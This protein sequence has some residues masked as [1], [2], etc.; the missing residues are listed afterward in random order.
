MSPLNARR[1]QFRWTGDAAPLEENWFHGRGQHS[2]SRDLVNGAR[3]YQLEDS[4]R[5][6][7]ETA[8]ELG[9]PLLVTG[10]PGTGKTQLAYYLAYKLGCGE[11][12]RFQVKSN[13][14][15][16]DLLYQFDAV[17]YFH[18]GRPS[19]TDALARAPLDP[20]Q[21]LTR[22][23]LWR[24]IESARPQVVL[25]DEIDKAPRDF[26]NDLL[27]ALDEYKWDVLETGES[28]QLPPEQWD[29][30]PVVIITSNLERKLPEPFL[31]RCLYCHLPFSKEL[32]E[33]SIR[34][35]SHELGT[36]SPAFVQLAI[37]R[38]MEVRNL[39]IR[40]RPSTAEAL[41]WFRALRLFGVD[42]EVLRRARPGEIPHLEALVKDKDDQDALTRNS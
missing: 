6:A 1:F 20:R 10:E 27:Q 25:I 18:A 35:R 4:V 26:P 31:R 13:S 22:G 16:T 17:K 30:R 38:F 9:E 7:V 2:S 29:R 32:L 3:F 15:A 24:A 37:E 19:P 21:F 36:P 8:L 42:E 40:K 12:L 14:L 33:R 23:V 28:V 11:P 39:A 41:V 5:I 34:A